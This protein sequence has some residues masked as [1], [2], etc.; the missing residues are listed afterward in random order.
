[1]YSKKEI[2]DLIVSIKDWN[3]T[4]TIDTKKELSQNIWNP[5]TKK[6]IKISKKDYTF[7]KFNT[8]IIKTIQKNNINIDQDEEII[9]LPNI[10][11]PDFVISIRNIFIKNRE[12]FNRNYSKYKK[13]VKRLLKFKY[14]KR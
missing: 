13:N 3:N 1:M 4:K 6:D 12:R 5:F 10:K 14:I 8:E 9:S 11:G 7:Q 2:N